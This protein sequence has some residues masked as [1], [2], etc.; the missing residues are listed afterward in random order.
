ML[1]T[2]ASRHR[3]KLVQCCDLASWERISV[4]VVQDWWDGD[5]YYDDGD[6]E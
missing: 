5:N 1:H 3:S 6:D 2:R 4:V